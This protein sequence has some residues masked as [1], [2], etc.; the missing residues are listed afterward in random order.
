M[1][2][3]H[4]VAVIA[5]AFLKGFDGIDWRHAYSAVRD[6]LRK[7][8][9]GRIKEDWDLYD[10]Y[11]YYPFDK[12]IGESVSRTLECSYDDWCAMK[13]AE[14]IGHED[15]AAFFRGRANCWTNVMDV[16]TGF[17]R[18][19][20]TQGRWRTPFDPF[21]L[22]HGADTANDFTEG[23][24]YQY[25]WHVLQDPEGLVEAMGGKRRACER[26]DALFAAS[27]KTVG[28]GL[29]VDVTGL[30]GQYAHGNEPSHH[31]PYLYQYAGRPDRTAERV[32]EICRKFYKNAP[33]G[34]CGNEDHG[35]MSAWYVFS[36]LGFYP[37]NPSSG[38][39]VI[40]AP[41]VKR[42]AIRVGGDKK[43]V[44]VANGLSE[45][46]RY[47]NSIS[48]NGKPLDGFIIGYKDIMAGGELVFEMTKV[49][50]KVDSL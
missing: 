43:F 20:D 14:S 50:S 9:K 28:P 48:L 31:I 32:R 4:S 24:A 30:I 21:Q 7:P 29:V 35:E 19:R 36:C 47:V 2:A 45:S 44:V 12:I 26:L 40:G 1:I 3:T 25:S 42:A 34:L 8:H 11:G 15:D 23:N 39:F 6:T 41:Q 33:D 27:D 22:G 5:D 18:G 38:E 13:M 46:R 16:S 49:E 17:V 10:R 37:L